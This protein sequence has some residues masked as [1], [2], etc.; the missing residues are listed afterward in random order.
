MISLQMK[1]LNTKFV[2]T[3]GILFGVSLGQ[4][5]SALHLTVVNYVLDAFSVILVALILLGIIYGLLRR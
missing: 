5:A 1:K 2:S 3:M 4:L